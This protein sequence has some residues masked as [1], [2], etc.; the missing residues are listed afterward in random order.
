[1]W[2]LSKG[3][4]TGEEDGNVLGNVLSGAE[5]KFRAKKIAF[6]RFSDLLLVSRSQ[7]HRENQHLTEELYVLKI[8]HGNEHWEKSA[9]TL[10]PLLYSDFP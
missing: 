9:P 5:G 7:C 4:C 2:S 6:R 10:V 1:M 3:G 8:I